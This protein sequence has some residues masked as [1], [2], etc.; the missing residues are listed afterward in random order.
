MGDEPVEGEEVSGI[1]H[2]EPLIMQIFEPR[3]ERMMT[4]K[5][6]ARRVSLASNDIHNIRFG[7]IF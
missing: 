5:L 6:Y 7:A 3:F 2:K 4:D 1:D